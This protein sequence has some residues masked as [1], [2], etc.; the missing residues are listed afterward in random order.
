MAV[1]VSMP[2][3]FLAVSISS[4]AAAVPIEPLWAVR[5]RC[6]PKTSLAGADGP[7]VGAVSAST[8]RI[9]PGD[10]SVTL[11]AVER[12]VPT[13]RSPTVSVR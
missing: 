11:P 13:R 10:S 12:I 5:M 9:D 3:G 8:S 7:P 1:A 4:S 6:A 2:A